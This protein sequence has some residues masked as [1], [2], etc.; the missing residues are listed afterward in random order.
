MKNKIVKV[1]SLLMV[2]MLVFVGCSS[3]PASNEGNNNEGNVTKESKVKVGLVVSGGLGDRSF[4]D[5]SNEG[6]ELA[7]KDLGVEGKVLECK[8]DL[9]LLSDQLVQASNYGDIIVVVGFEFYEVIQEIAPQFPTKTYVYVDNAITGVDNI[10]SIQYK[11]N[12]GSFLA[13]AL[14]AMLSETGHIGMVGGVDLPVIRNFQV[15]YEE[16]AKYINS[17]IKA[18]VIFAGDFEDPTKG[19]ES[20][21]AIYNKGA[22]IV[23]HAAGK[24]GEG[25]F[26]AGKDLGKF[27]IGVDSDQRYINPDVIMYSMIKNVG[28]SVYETIENIG[29]GSVKG[30]EILTYGIKENGIGIGYGTNDMKQFVNDEMKA[31]LEEITEK[32]ISGEIKVTEAR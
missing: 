22:D 27:A 10:V 9:S 5:S 32:I 19:K 11:E 4:Y 7:K 14:A 25:V 15:G 17:D 21:I 29:N 12:E 16:G 2:A 6:L 1:I 8:N 3:K 18:D 31:K 28:L 13:G 30:G 26:E 20:A 24:T 23:F